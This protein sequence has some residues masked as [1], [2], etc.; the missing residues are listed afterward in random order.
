MFG[1]GKKNVIRISRKSFIPVYF[2]VLVLVAII[3]Y[4]KI[5]GLPLSEPLFIAAILF[6]LFT[7]KFTEL[8]RLLH[9]YDITPMALEKVEGFFVQRVKRMHYYSISNLHLTQSLWAKILDI[10][11]IEVAQFSETLRTEIKNINK[12]REFMKNVSEMI[13]MSGGRGF[14]KD[15]EVQDD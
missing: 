14:S 9:H 5:K 2:M 11:T 3:I 4:I 15:Q 8:H 12:P 13:A 1:L 7:I 6:I 10:G